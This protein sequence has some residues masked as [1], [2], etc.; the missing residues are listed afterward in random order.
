MLLRDPRRVAQDEQTQRIFARLYSTYYLQ[1]THGI[2]TGHFLP[3]HIRR[4]SPAYRKLHYVEASKYVLAVAVRLSS[5]IVTIPHLSSLFFTYIPTY[6][7]Y[8]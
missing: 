4:K 6:R 2:Q 1:T 5:P 8:S 7:H 3:R